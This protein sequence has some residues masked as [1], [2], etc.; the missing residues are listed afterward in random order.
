[1]SPTHT[2]EM[3]ICNN[4]AQASSA[5]RCAGKQK[6]SK[7]QSK[8]DSEKTQNQNTDQIY[9]RFNLR[10]NTIIKVVSNDKGKRGEDTSISRTI[11]C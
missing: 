7:V 8:T 4:K 10:S 11:I 6:V 9:G 1:M 2:A 3:S 5:V